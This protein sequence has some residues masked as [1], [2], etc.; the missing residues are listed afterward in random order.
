MKGGLTVQQ[1]KAIV[2]GNK[3]RQ[4]QLDTNQRP[5]RRWSRGNKLQVEKQKI[6]L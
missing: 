4:K 1:P 5:T 6:N 3:Q 2:G